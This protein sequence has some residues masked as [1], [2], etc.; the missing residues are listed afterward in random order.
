[1]TGL[2]KSSSTI[3]FNNTSD[4]HQSGGVSSSSQSTS[5]VNIHKRSGSSIEDDDVVKPKKYKLISN[6]IKTEELPEDRTE[7]LKV[8][9]REIQVDKYRV[10]LVSLSNF[11]Q[12][13]DIN[14]LLK[15]FEDVFRD[16]PRTFYILKGMRRF[17]KNRSHL[18][19]FDA[20]VE[21]ITR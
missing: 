8:L 10:L 13:D 15:V 7:L 16:E 19:L 18:V 1:M 9:K 2:K 12:N 5:L 17:L 14:A 4:Y 20:L 11:R 21:R 3:D 6:P